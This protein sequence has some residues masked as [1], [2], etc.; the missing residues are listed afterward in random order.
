MFEV[1]K[2]LTWVGLGSMILKRKNA[3]KVNYTFTSTTSLRT[4]F[5]IPGWRTRAEK[6]KVRV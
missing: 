1:I 6:K 5:K 4:F 3:L 2:E